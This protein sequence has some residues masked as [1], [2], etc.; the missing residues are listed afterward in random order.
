MDSKDRSLG[1]GAPC[2]G[3]LSN[4]NDDHSSLSQKA[5]AKIKRVSICK[6]LGPCL[7]LSKSSFLLYL[8]RLLQW[9]NGKE[10]VCQYRRHKRCGFDPWVAKIPWSRKWQPIPGFLLGKFQEEPGRLQT[11]G[12]PRVGHNSTAQWSA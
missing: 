8:E 7:A 3:F 9:H 11:T 10:S 6:C 2:V 1:Y 5:V 4:G 12:S